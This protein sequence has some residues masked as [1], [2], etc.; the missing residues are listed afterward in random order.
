MGYYGYENE[1]DYFA[2]QAG[3]AYSEYV[4]SEK[5]AYDK[6]LQDEI[7]RLGDIRNLSQNGSQ[8]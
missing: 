2:E 7:E 8:C 1:Q 6:H 4:E 3:L 5:A